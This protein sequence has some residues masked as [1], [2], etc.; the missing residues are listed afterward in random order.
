MGEALFYLLGHQL[1][2]VKHT[3]ILPPELGIFMEDGMVGLSFV[4]CVVSVV[5]RDRV[6]RCFIYKT[7]YSPD[8]H[9]SGHVK[10]SERQ[11]VG[12]E[13]GHSDP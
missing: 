2:M 4:L 6:G 8:Y 13:S 7:F 5:K 9:H 10:P 1:E 11:Q 3:T 12:A